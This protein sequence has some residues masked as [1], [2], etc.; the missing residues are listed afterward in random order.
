MKSHSS[1]SRK[2]LVDRFE[3]VQDEVREGRNSA[4]SRYAANT[5]GFFH[6]TVLPYVFPVKDVQLPPVAYLEGDE[7]WGKLGD[8]FSPDGRGFDRI[9]VAAA[10]IAEKNAHGIAYWRFGPKKVVVL[11][12]QPADIKT[13]VKDNFAN[14]HFHDST[15]SFKM[16]FGPDSI[17]NS[18]HNSENWKHLRQRFK[19]ALLTDSALG[20]DIAPMQ[21]IIDGVIARIVQKQD[22]TIDDL[23]QFSNSLT[24]DMIGKTKLGFEHIDE[25]I[26]KRISD[27]IAEATVEVANPRNQLIDEYLPFVKYFYKSHLKVLLDQGF[28]VLRNN[29]IKPN[30]KNIRETDNWLHEEGSAERLDLYSQ[31]TIFEITQFLVAGHETTAKLLLMSLLLLGDAQHRDV[32]EKVYTEI[33]SQGISPQEW[34]T[35]NLNNMPYLTAVLKETLRLYPPIPDILFKVAKPFSFAAGSLNKDDIVV[36][37]PRITHRNKAIFGEDADL[38]RPERFLE[39]SFG[40]FENFTFGFMPRPC[41]G[42]R[43]SMQE[44][45]LTL[46]RLI[47]LFDIKHDLQFPFPHHQIFTLRVDLEDIKMKFHLRSSLEHEAKQS[48]SNANLGQP[49]GLLSESDMRSSF[50]L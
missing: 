46:A 6:R 47:A 36:I 24:M 48:S 13:I 43:F 17:F 34:T 45:K 1:N 20:K 16:F 26:K 18:P 22:H 49:P 38:F 2:T 9:I 40:E 19:L 28:D 14:I 44:V 5:L 21:R 41:P 8:V 7:Y 29:I 35:E 15:G 4:C 31:K 33:L 12:T 10:P 37:S 3:E 32:L 27:I 11:V 39:K 30:E 42:Q 25:N 50:R 23:E